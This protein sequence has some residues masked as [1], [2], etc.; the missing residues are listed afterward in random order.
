[1]AKINEIETWP[2][3]FHKWIVVLDIRYGVNDHN[4]KQTNSLVYQVIEFSY[5][6]RPEHLWQWQCSSFSFNPF[7]ILI[8]NFFDVFSTMPA[9]SQYFSIVHLHSQHRYRCTD[10]EHTR[11]RRYED[12]RWTLILHNRLKCVLV[13]CCLRRYVCCVVVVVIFFFS[14]CSDLY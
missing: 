2:V 1:M 11:P 9:A 3:P 4:F 13:P 14:F 5:I 12:P 10:T 6:V 7:C 8:L